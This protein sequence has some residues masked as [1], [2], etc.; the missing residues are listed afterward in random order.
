[1]LVKRKLKLMSAFN[2]DSLL[3]LL[4]I[5][6][7]STGKYPSKDQ[8]GNVIYT[9]ADVFSQ[10]TL[11]TCLILSLSEF[12]QVPKFTYYDFSNEMFVRTFSE[13]LIEGAVIHALAARS[14]IERG[15]EYAMIDSGIA[16]NPP[17][18]SDLMSTQFATLYS[19][20]YEKL[21]YIKDHI[22]WFQGK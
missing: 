15:R 19:V 11:K 9:D 20:H 13:I 6:L 5:R 7:S 10:E 3:A 17:A 22:D 2:G 8:H 18:I 4:Q 12:N 14:L 16:F 1:M 21:K